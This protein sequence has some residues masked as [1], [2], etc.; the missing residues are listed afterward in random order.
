MKLLFQR[1]TSSR[2][3]PCHTKKTPIPHDWQLTIWDNDIELECRKC[4]HITWLPKYE[5]VD[6][7]PTD[8]TL[9]NEFTITIK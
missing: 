6:V 4:H 2:S 5:L 9:F 7:L 1:I 3:I 8:D